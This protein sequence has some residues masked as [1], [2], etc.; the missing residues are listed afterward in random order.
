M[1]SAVRRNW[2]MAG[3][4]FESALTPAAPAPEPGHPAGPA[5]EGA[6]GAFVAGRLARSAGARDFKLYVPLGTLAGPRP[7]IVML[8]GCQQDPDDFALA[9]GMNLA[10]QELGF[11]VLYPA[12]STQA[13]PHRCWN[14]FKPGH[15]GRGRGEPALLVAMVREVVARHTIDPGRIYVAGLS[16]GGAMAAILGALY[17]DVFAAVGVHSG[18]PRGA[19]RDLRTALDAMRGD[20]LVPARAVPVPAPGAPLIVIHG[21]AD[22]TVHPVNGQGLFDTAGQAAS[23]LEITTVAAGARRG[24]TRRLRR[25]A[26]GRIVVEH[27]LVHGGTHGWSGGHRQGSFSDPQGPDATEALLRFFSQH[28]L[29]P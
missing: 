12:Q 8:H 21:D 5:A 10:A 15:Q 24:Y 23:P 27:W 3:A 13:N 18:L 28:R 29:Q 25:D 2:R 4:F 11:Y 16:A 22:R 20:R 19:A 6:I 17:G 26:Q 7:L 1:E 14:W 9:T